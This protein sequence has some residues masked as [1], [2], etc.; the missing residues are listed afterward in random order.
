MLAQAEAIHMNRLFK[1]LDDEHEENQRFENQVFD[2]LNDQEELEELMDEHLDIIF[3]MFVNLLLTS[4]QLNGDLD[5]AF[6]K[7][8]SYLFEVAEETIRER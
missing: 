3:P 7:I 5:T 2:L 4:R 1:S 6:D 8:E